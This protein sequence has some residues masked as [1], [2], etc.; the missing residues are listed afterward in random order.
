MAGRESIHRGAGGPAS[1][2][3]N[4]RSKITPMKSSLFSRRFLWLLAAA[5][6]G[7]GL[8]LC[9][10]DKA[11]PHPPLTLQLDPAAIDRNAS[12]PVSY[13]P[14]VK[15]T[16]ASVVYV[17]STKKVRQP[18]MSQYFQDPMFRRFFGLPDPGQAQPREQ[19]QHSLGSG[20]IVAADGYVLT[21]NHVIDG[22]DEVKVAFG[23]PRK[24]YKATVVGRDARLRD[25]G[26]RGTRRVHRDAAR[27]CGQHGRA[28]HARGRCNASKRHCSSGR[29]SMSR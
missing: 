27:A 21:N 16:A 2:S 3:S 10:K 25:A 23:E 13:A 17:F 5:L 9:A 4:R 8:A 28:Q 7:G 6:F 19:V 11:A 26:V 20:V 1:G 24:E 15:K 29:F 12:S 18:D 14:I 22:A